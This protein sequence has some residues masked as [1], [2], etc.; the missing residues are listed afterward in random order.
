MRW[1]CVM[2]EFIVQCLGLLSNGVE[3]CEIVLTMVLIANG[4]FEFQSVIGFAVSELFD[5]PHLNYSVYLFGLF[6]LLRLNYIGGKSP[7]FTASCKV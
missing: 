3:D 4:R 5:L 7:F 6:D 1:C 2:V